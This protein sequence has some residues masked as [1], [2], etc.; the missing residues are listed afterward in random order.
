MAVHLVGRSAP[1][2][3]RLSGAVPFRGAMVVRGHLLGTTFLDEES[4]EQARI[5]CQGGTDAK[6]GD[7]CLACPR[8]LSYE[9]G[10]EPG[11]VVVTCAW[12]HFDPVSARMTGVRALVAV[13]STTECGEAARLAD[14]VGVHHLLVV[15]GGSLVGVASSRDLRTDAL[16]PVSSVMAGEVFAV[17][18]SASL[19]EAAAAMSALNI[20]CLPVVRDGLVVGIVTLGDLRRAGL[21]A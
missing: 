13:P 15:D 11:E 9:D 5:D 3:L 17:A 7:Q 10:D 20:G 18:P 14:E 4:F 19:G 21:Q 8:L 6:R 12:A 2:N 16:A 1:A